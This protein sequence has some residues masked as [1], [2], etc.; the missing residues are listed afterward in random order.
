MGRQEAADVLSG[1]RDPAVE[2]L[3]KALDDLEPPVRCCPRAA[4]DLW[5]S[6]RAH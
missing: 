6:G 4:R 2:A 5:A 1:V 3:I